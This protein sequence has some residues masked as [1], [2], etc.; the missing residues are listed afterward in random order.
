MLP[1][2]NDMWMIQ[3]LLN[4]SIIAH[5]LLCLAILSGIWPKLWTDSCGY[6]FCVVNEASFLNNFSQSVCHALLFQ[7]TCTFQGTRVNTCT[8]FFLFQSVGTIGHNIFF[9]I[10]YILFFFKCFEKLRKKKDK[11]VIITIL[12]WCVKNE[13]PWTLW[14]YIMYAGFLQGS[15][16]RGCGSHNQRLEPCGQGKTGIWE[17]RL[18]KTCC[19]SNLC[20]KLLQNSFETMKSLVNFVN[21][22]TD[23]SNNT[24][25]PPP[26]KKKLKVLVPI[27]F[28]QLKNSL[29]K[30][31]FL[32]LIEVCILILF[33]KTTIHA[34]FWMLQAYIQITYVEPYFDLY[35][36]RERVTYFERNY[37]ISKIF[38]LLLNVIYQKYYFLVRIDES[39]EN[40]YHSPSLVGGSVIIVVRRQKL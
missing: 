35:E 7:A 9:Q 6:H 38:V 39:P 4:P 30:V 40:Y 32:S 18:C 20:Y 8:A 25:S 34:W 17:G 27:E 21:S 36:F 19:K 12:I 29:K 28:Q 37:N 13:L 10:L 1:C 15:V 31:I 11:K 16:W 5:S 33:L 26:K 24:P 3:A 2:L 22:N 23:N 14:R